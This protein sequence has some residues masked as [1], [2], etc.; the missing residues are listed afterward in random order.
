MNGYPNQDPDHPRGLAYA[1]NGSS[2]LS[3]VDDIRI[4]IE[5]VLAIGTGASLGGLLA[6]VVASE[7]GANLFCILDLEIPDLGGAAK[8]ATTSVACF[9]WK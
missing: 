8:G 3:S 4:G 5:T 6:R 7:L 2:N 9:A 1:P